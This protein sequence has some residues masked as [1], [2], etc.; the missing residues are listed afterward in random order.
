MWK[1]FLMEICG[2]LWEFVGIFPYF[3]TTKLPK[4]YLL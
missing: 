2:Y 3:V 4:V 1:S